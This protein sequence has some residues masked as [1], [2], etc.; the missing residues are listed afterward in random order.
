MGRGRQK[1]RLADR[2]SV[3]RLNSRIAAKANNRFY[4]TILDERTLAASRQ[5]IVHRAVLGLEFRIIGVVKPSSEDQFQQTR[6]GRDIE[7]R[8]LRQNVLQKRRSCPRHGA[9]VKYFH[10]DLTSTVSL[11]Q[12]TVNISKSAETQLHPVLGR[13]EGAFARRSISSDV[14]GTRFSAAH[15]SS[16]GW[17]QSQRQ[18]RL[19]RPA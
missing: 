9:L 1:R 11:T 6:G 8:V 2:S 18:P 14:A 5:I 10:D 7:F 13:F 4:G 3:K 12:G 16:P 15:L 17:Q 19:R